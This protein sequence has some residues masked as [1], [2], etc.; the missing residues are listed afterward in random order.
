M[1]DRLSLINPEPLGCDAN[2][3][4]SRGPTAKCRNTFSFVALSGTRG[5]R[6]R[7]RRFFQ[8]GAAPPYELRGPKTIPELLKESPNVRTISITCCSADW[9]WS[10]VNGRNGCRNAD[11]TIPCSK[12]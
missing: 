7:R 4:R 12:A 3:P 10:S 1:S 6:L 5:G 8:S 9:N 2:A 11:I